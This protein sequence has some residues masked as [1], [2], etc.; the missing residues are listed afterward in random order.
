MKTLDLEDSQNLSREE[1]D[2]I[3]NRGSIELVQSIIDGCTKEALHQGATEVVEDGPVRNEEGGIA[4]P[5]AAIGEVLIPEE[6]VEVMDEVKEEVLDLILDEQNE[7]LA[8]R[9]IKEPIQKM[10]GRKR[11]MQGLEVIQEDTVRQWLQELRELRSEGVNIPLLLD[12]VPVL[13]RQEADKFVP[14]RLQDEKNTP[15]N[16][17]SMLNMDEQLVLVPMLMECQGPYSGY[18]FFVH[19]LIESH[20]GDL[21]LSEEII[22]RSLFGMIQR[23]FAVTDVGIE[24]QDAIALSDLWGTSGLWGR[25]PPVDIRNIKDA[26]VSLFSRLTARDLAQTIINM[27]EENTTELRPFITRIN[28]LDTW[29]PLAPAFGTWLVSK[30]LLPLINSPYVIPTFTE[31]AAARE[32]P[33]IRHIGRVVTKPS[34]GF[35][36]QCI[37]SFDIGEDFEDLHSLIQPELTFAR[38]VPNDQGELAG[39]HPSLSRGGTLE[40]RY[41]QYDDNRLLGIVRISPTGPVESGLRTNLH[42]VCFIEWCEKHDIVASELSNDD[43]I[44]LWAKFNMGITLGILKNE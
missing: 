20:G 33:M 15:E 16:I 36:S 1:V 13:C 34:D 27:V 3:T 8:I 44:N 42:T 28:K 32:D 4:W 23:E 22:G 6:W 25:H 40:V 35:A 30:A 5:C 39:T 43:F 12:F 19:K 31:A 14:V 7:A 10:L 41:G 37:R 11:G 2:T 26:D 9:Q 21:D 38:L 29:H 18:G 24:G 17:L